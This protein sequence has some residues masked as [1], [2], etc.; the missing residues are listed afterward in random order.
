MTPKPPRSVRWYSAVLFLVTLIV[1]V[2][3]GFWMPRDDEFFAIRKNFQIFGALYEELVTNYVDALN[4][5]QVM[6]TGIESML[7]DLDPYTVF[8]DEANNIDIDILTRGRYGGIGLNIGIRNGQV[9]VSSPIENTG[10]YEQGVRAGDIITTIAGQSTEGMALTDVNALLRG[11][12]GTAVEMTIVREGEP[13]PLP[14]LLTREEVEL[15]NVSYSGFL[16]DDPA[17]G[18]AYVKLERFGR[19]AADEVKHALDI[20]QATAPI[21]G[22]VLDLRDNLGG[23]LDEAVSLTQFFVP[24]GSTIVSTRGRLS[25]TERVYRST[26]QPLYPEIPVAVLVNE[27]SA[28]ASEIVAG[29][30]QDLDRGV[31][32]GV[33]SFGKGLVQIVR[34]LPYNTSIKITT[35]KY[36]TPSGRS[37]Q[38]I[39]YGRHDGSS[40]AIPDSL[41]R[42]FTTLGGREVKDGRGIEPDVRVSFGEESELEEALRRR[43]AFFFYANHYAATHSQI[44]PNFV[45]SDAIYDDFRAWLNREGFTYSTSMEYAMGDLSE[46]LEANGYSSTGDEIAALNRALAQEKAMDFNR[47]EPRLKERLRAEILSRYL[48]R[49]KQVRASLANDG[50]V[51]RAERILQDTR[52]YTSILD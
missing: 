51:L 22:V 35:A 5:E 46:Q 17:A 41:R 20:L 43:A 29:A 3:V 50:Q 47:H 25:N 42:T 16:K 49:D 26:M 21:Q 48:D 19:N 6:R 52:E 24:H 10:G 9:T 7:E 31:I 23:L 28:S 12:P 38:A 30:I 27:Y 33:S 15:H 34:P 40:E 32:V 4:P 2:T 1:G 45:V 36:Y 13:E 18:M 11:E 37:I 39:D 44:E 14:F 8:I